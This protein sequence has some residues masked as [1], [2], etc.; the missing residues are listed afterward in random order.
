MKIAVFSDIHGNLPA[1]RTVLQHIRQ[2]D[3]DGIYCLGDMFTP[4]PG[5][6]EIWELLKANQVQC[7]LGNNEVALLAQ[8]EKTQDYGSDEIR[9]RPFLLNA[10]EILPFLPE[11][12]QIPAKRTL[13]MTDDLDIHLCHYSP[14]E[15]MRGL[16]S[17][18]DFNI[19]AYIQSLP[20]PILL[21]GHL[22][23]FEA[24][25]KY[26]KTVYCVGSAG[27]PLKG[28]HQLEYILGEVI[29][30]EFSITYRLIPYDVR[31]AVDYLLQYEFLS[32]VGPIAWLA[33]DEILTQRDRLVPF[34]KDFLPG[35]NDS[36]VDYYLSVEQFLRSLH[37]WDEIKKYISRSPA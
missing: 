26:G 8:H 13:A 4:F 14:G 6:R 11:L 24:I 36:Q 10:R 33:F 30:G 20:E 15:V 32:K 16:H 31:E 12:Q 18:F 1:L 28:S 22:H 9:F 34:F 35:Q 5:S 17:I 37:R 21:T 7:V 3:V 25:D 29:H 27:L 19:D 23:K 2:E